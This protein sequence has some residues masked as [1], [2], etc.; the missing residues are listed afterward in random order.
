V[1]GTRDGITTRR[2]VPAVLVAVLGQL[3]AAPG[4]MALTSDAAIA[5][6]AA[7]QSAAPAPAPAAVIGREQLPPGAKVEPVAGPF[8]GPVAL[9][10]TPEGGLLVTE[11]HGAVRII[12]G[13]VPRA[14]PLLT[15]PTDQ[16]AERGLIGVAVD[17]AF[18]VTRRVFVYHT[19]D[20]PPVNRIVRFRLADGRAVDVTPVYTLPQSGDIHNGGNLRF[21]PDGML[22]AGVGEGGVPA[23]APDLADRRGKILRLDPSTT[24]LSPAPGNPFAG[25]AG[26]DAAVWASGLRNPFDFTFDPQS[27]ALWATDNGPDCHDE[28]N[29]VRPARDYGWRP[30]YDCAHPEGAAGTDPPAWT[31]PQTIGVTGPAAYAG[32]AV[33]QWRGSLFACGWND[34]ALYRA[35]LSRDRAR[36]ERMNVV[37]GVTCHLGLTMGPDGAL[38]Y[39][40]GGGYLPGYVRRITADP[41]ATPGP[42][43]TT[44]PPDRAWLPWVQ[45]Q[46]GPR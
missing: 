11:K 3:P 22:Y 26:A 10:F 33:P 5:N 36:I 7:S 38:Y 13:G 12:E 23:R 27:R 42:R 14:A 6:A 4:P 46:R 28:I 43:P 20:R 15:L 30:G 34:A 16:R 24:P 45:Q 17:P 44:P 19:L 31:W 18:A 8:S 25:L 35:D 9:A 29:R 21:G 39:L 1:T 40:E 41:D 2:V 37:A 32:D